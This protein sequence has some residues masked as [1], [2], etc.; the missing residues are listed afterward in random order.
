METKDAREPDIRIWIQEWDNHPVDY[1]RYKLDEFRKIRNVMEHIQSGAYHLRFLS[2]WF[3]PRVGYGYHFD[4]L[5]QNLQHIGWLS[6]IDEDEAEIEI[7]N[8]HKANTRIY[9]G[10]YHD[11]YLLN[12]IWDHTIYSMPSTAIQK[13]IKATIYETL[14]RDDAEICSLL[15]DEDENWYLPSLPY[16]D[17]SREDVLTGEYQRLCAEAEDS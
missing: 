5:N 10:G 11:K 12:G 1:L 17:V 4:M 7:E 2:S 9:N 6:L 13:L 8:A 16:T 14:P 3:N 15:T